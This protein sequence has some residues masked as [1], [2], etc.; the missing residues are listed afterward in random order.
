MCSQNEKLLR[1]YWALYAIDS[2]VKS[3]ITSQKA[4]CP[5]VRKWKAWARDIF[6]RKLHVPPGKKKHP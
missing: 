5:C 1:E 3:D 6:H 2:S 4:R